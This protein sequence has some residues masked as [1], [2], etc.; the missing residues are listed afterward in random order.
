MAITT[1]HPEQT[2]VPCYGGERTGQV[3]VIE[4]VKERRYWFYAL[5]G[6]HSSQDSEQ[7]KA[8]LV[9]KI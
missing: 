6:Y 2:A 3:Q 5:G 4:A 1:G 9:L 7:T 8:A